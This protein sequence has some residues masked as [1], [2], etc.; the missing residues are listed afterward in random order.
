M[1]AESTHETDTE[2]LSFVVLWVESATTQRILTVELPSE[3]TASE[4]LEIIDEIQQNSCESQQN[5]VQADENSTSTSGR[6]LLLYVKPR[7]FPVLPIR[8]ELYSRPLLELLPT[9]SVAIESLLVLVSYAATVQH[10]PKIFAEKHQRPAAPEALPDEPLRRGG[11]NRG[12]RGRF[13]QKAKQEENEIDS[14]EIEQLIS[15]AENAASRRQYR[16]Y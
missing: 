15:K 16:R 8:S 3:I 11:F 12:G 1:S 4:A 7:G 9:T 13:T 5:L 6:N 14:D 2:L 10:S